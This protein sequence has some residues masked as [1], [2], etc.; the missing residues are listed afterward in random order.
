MGF[1]S[2]APG[3]VRLQ[4]LPAEAFAAQNLADDPDGLLPVDLLRRAGLGQCGEVR[5]DLVAGGRGKRA[6]VALRPGEHTGDRHR[7]CD[8]SP[9]GDAM[10]RQKRQVWLLRP[11]L[12][13]DRQRVEG[14]LELFDLLGL[15]LNPTTQLVERSGG[16]RHAP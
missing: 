13:G 7:Q 16:V 6:H 15:L 1:E 9:S 3:A 12:Y 14:V 10:L 8:P 2:Q 11:V 5:K 4:G